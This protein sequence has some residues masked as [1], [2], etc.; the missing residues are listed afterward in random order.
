MLVR[1]I[2]HGRAIRIGD[3]VIH[4]S[5]ARRGEVKLAIDAPS[6]VVVEVLPKQPS[7]SCPVS[8]TRR[9]CPADCPH[10]PF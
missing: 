8:C 6:E 5:Y 4:V 2:R 10:K 7:S 9:P 1:K 3:A